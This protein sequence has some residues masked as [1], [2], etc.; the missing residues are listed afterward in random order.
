MVNGWV[1]APD[2]GRYVKQKASC[3]LYAGIESSRLQQKV[4]KIRCTKKC[5]NEM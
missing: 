5:F 4:K 1:K 2:T 3:P